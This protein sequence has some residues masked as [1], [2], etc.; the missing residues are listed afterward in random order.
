MTGG[1]PPGVKLRPAEGLQAVDF[2]IQGYWVWQ[3]FLEALA[4]VG[5]DSNNIA[6]AAFDWRLAV[7]LMEQRDA[8]FTRTK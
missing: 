1:D 2:F 4:D 6:T 8:W 3:K 7:P 5:Y